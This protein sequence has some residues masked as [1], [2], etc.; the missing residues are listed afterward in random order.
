MSR[1]KQLIQ[2]IHRRSLWQ[3]LGI[4]L[5]ASWVV[6]QVI[7][8]LAEGLGLP[9]WFPALAVVLLLNGLP[10]VLATAFV[11]EGL[12]RSEAQRERSADAEDAEWPGARVSSWG[13]R[14]SLTL[15]RF[16]RATRP[17]RSYMRRPTT[18]PTVL[19]GGAI[20]WG[21]EFTVPSQ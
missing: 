3:V 9:E 18:V 13:S 1:L 12:G 19:G 10:I 8:T 15:F 2:E 5:L 14:T 11:R 4:Y 16:R 7:Q 17:P 20:T 21:F 6:F